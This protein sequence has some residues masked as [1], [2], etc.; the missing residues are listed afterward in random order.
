MTSNMHREVRGISENNPRILTK[1]EYF[2]FLLVIKKL[3]AK[4]ST[5]TVKR[6][7]RGRQG[8]CCH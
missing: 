2:P 6:M 8:F 5:E 1:L 7:D 4:E 3:A